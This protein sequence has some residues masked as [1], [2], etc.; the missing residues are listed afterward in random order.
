MKTLNL[1]D[2]SR[3]HI[4][5]LN[6]ISVS[7]IGDYN[8]LIEDIFYATDRSI[9]W[10]VSSTLSRNTYLNPLFI[11]LCYLQLV[12][13]AIKEDREIE[14]V[15]V[16]T[17]ELKA[18]LSESFKKKSLAIEIAVINDKVSLKEGIKK[19]IRPL[20]DLYLNVCRLFV[21]WL[22]GKKK[23]KNK[24]PKDRPVTLIDTF[25]LSQCSRIIDLVI[26]IIQAC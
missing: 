21:M 14:K 8:S 22:L 25:F 13:L 20:F 16:P 5:L 3:E 9:D 11:N 19:R 17:M 4:I 7:I 6:A 1:S 10:L 26:D 2:L 24:F 23:R 15:V 12:K 18:V